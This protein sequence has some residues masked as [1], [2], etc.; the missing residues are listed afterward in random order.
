MKK[1]LKESGLEPGPGA[2]ILE[3]TP[4]NSEHVLT[5]FIEQLLCA[6]VSIEPETAMALNTLFL[7][8]RSGVDSKGGSVVGNEDDEEEDDLQTYEDREYSGD[9]WGLA[10]EC[11]SSFQVDDN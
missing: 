8:I 4:E 6:G 10:N 7:S 5:T 11:G 2:P 9:L 3:I 1:W